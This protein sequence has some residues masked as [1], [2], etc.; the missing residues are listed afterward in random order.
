MTK[1][2]GK[3]GRKFDSSVPKG[4]RDFNECPGFFLIA[5]RML[6]SIAPT[7]HLSAACDR[8]F[9]SRISESS[10]SM[11]SSLWWE[12]NQLLSS[13]KRQTIAWRRTARECVI[14]FPSLLSS[15][16]RTAISSTTGADS[17]IRV[18][19]ARIAGRSRAQPVPMAT[20]NDS[21]RPQVAIRTPLWNVAADSKSVAF[22]SNCSRLL[23][24]QA[25]AI[26]QERQLKRMQVAAEASPI[27]RDRPLL[28]H[29]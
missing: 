21:C 23:S 25:A 4:I 13:S 17:D 20:R 19:T 1:P 5:S 3:D 11:Q 16:G 15:D 28:R 22:P 2:F 10:T 12:W 26:G 8:E 9:L 6:V 18:K 7:R 29:F 24:N 14:S 27:L